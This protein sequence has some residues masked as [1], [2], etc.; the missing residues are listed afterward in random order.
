MILA[1]ASPRRSELLERLGCKFEVLPAQGEEQS[2]AS[3]PEDYVME[4]SR[5]KALEVY[6]R[7]CAAHR[8]G[9]AE[10]A[11]GTQEHFRRAG[12][13]AVAAGASDQAGSAAE[14]ADESDQLGSAA[15][16][17]DETEQ[18]L[19]VIAAD[20]VVVKD[21]VILGK[22]ADRSDAVRML[23]LLSGEVHQVY[24]G[25]CVCRR[26]GSESSQPACHSFCEMTEVE[27]YPMTEEEIEAYVESGDPM[28]KAGAYG[29]QSG[30]MRFVKQIRGDYNNVVGLPAARLYQE[31]KGMREDMD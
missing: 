4:L 21:G 12:R 7:R 29:I 2:E 5:H 11:D 10:I 8:G 13:A 14:A 27:F 3:R 24:T 31:I 16:T 18:T 25:V 6:A 17:V 26:S 1:S 28:D 9:A 23:R 19:T 22:P 15:E 30:G 20:T